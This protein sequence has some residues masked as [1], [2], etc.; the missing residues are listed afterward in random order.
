MSRG[1]TPGTVAALETPFFPALL[2]MADWPDGVERGHTGF[3]D[4]TWDGHTW[5]GLGPLVRWDVPE[6]GIGGW[7]PEASVRFAGALEALLDQMGTAVRGRAVQVW[8]ALTE[9]PG[10]NAIKAGTTPFPMFSGT[11][12]SRKLERM[13]RGMGDLTHDLSFGLVMGPPFRARVSV[14][15]SHED[16][17]ARYPTDTGFRHVQHAV[18]R[19]SNPPVW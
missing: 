14:R 12:G 1:A 9:T 18:K 3:G 16:Q 11:F 13:A 6:E 15:H 2:V 17:I 4:L 10:G 19:A 7:T 5:T 8:L